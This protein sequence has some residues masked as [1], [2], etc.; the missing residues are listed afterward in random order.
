M[1][2]TTAEPSAYDTFAD[3]TSLV[4]RKVGYGTGNNFTGGTDLNYV[5]FD[6]ENGVAGG[7]TYTAEG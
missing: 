2:R 1:S 4:S 7:N 3:N 6:P 5:Y